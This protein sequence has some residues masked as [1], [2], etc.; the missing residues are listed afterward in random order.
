[1]PTCV[2]DSTARLG[3]PAK[4][5]NCS[6]KSSDIRV[7]AHSI[8]NGELFTFAHGGSIA[9]GEW[10]YIGEG[11]RIWSAQEVSIGNR[12]LV[13]HNVNIFDTLT[14]PLEAGA[15]HAHFRHIATV[16]HPKDI[17]LD[18]RPV[19]IE[20]DAW[21]GA[22][23]FVLRGVRVGRGAI[24]GAGA[25]VTRSVPP[26]AIVAGNPARVIGEAPSAPAA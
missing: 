7:G 22:G 14:H 5:I 6:G 9:I 4:V 10:C 19:V 21:I 15:R 8:V 23:A 16:G 3:W 12:V 20:D 25:V 1:M 18:E 13:A 17:A 2:A 24:V 11:T 26:G